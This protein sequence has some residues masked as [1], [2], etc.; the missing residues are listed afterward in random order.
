[1]RTFKLFVIL[2]GLFIFL[3]TG[4]AANL[5]PHL[6][7]V[8]E[9]EYLNSQTSVTPIDLQSTGQCPGTRTLHVVNKESRTEK[10]TAY[11]VAGVTYKIVPIEYVDIVAQYMEDK[12]RESKVSVDEKT[13]KE[14]DI[15]M[16]E[17]SADGAWSFGCDVKLKIAIPEIDY[18]HVYRGYEGSGNL[19]NAIGY[20]TNLAIDEFLNDPVVVRYIQCSEE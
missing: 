12:L 6:T 18:T 14:I 20:A 9:T 5:T 11:S 16:E 17:V 4:C 1:M 13:G 2:M 8:F 3:F 10:Y 19:I 7:K 15:W